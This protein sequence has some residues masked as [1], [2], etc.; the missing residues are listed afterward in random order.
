[1]AYVV[2]LLTD[3]EMEILEERGWD[4]EEPPAELK[5]GRCPPGKVQK[6]VWVDSD[7][8]EIIGPWEDRSFSDG[9]PY[10]A[11]TATGMYDRY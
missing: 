9:P 2:G 10:D 6:M 7:M 3:E 1:M 4:F 5:L 11:A 8:F